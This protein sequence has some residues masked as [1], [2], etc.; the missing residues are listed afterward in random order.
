MNKNISPVSI[1]DLLQNIDIAFQGDLDPYLALFGFEKNTEAGR[2]YY[3]KDFNAS[4]LG[5]AHIDTVNPITA[6]QVEG[7][8]LRSTGV[9]DRLGLHLLLNVLQKA[10]CEFDI[11]LST[12][13]EIGQSTAQFFKTEKKYHWI[14]E[15]DRRESGVVLYQYDNPLLRSILEA[16]GFEIHIGSFS[17][18]CYLEHLGVSGMNFGTGYRYEHQLKAEATLSMLQDQSNKF[19]QFYQDY[20]NIRL[21]HPFP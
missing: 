5:I 11:L 3:F 19:L 18:I 9:D 14:F 6:P 12:D 21:P 7:D 16:K 2:P 10:G 15:F 17:D 4:I 13:E 1:S 20:K 8:I